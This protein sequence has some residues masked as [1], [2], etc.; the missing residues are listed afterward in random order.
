MFKNFIKNNPVHK[1][2]A[3]KFDFLFLFNL[4]SF[5]VKMMVFC[6]GMSLS[7]YHLAIHTNYFLLN[8]KYIDLIYFISLFIFISLSNFYEQI[9]DLPKLK[10]KDK[11]DN[12]KV[13]LN[14]LYVC[15]NFISIN[16]VTFLND[17]KLLV[18]A[19]LPILYISIESAIFLVL[20]YL[21]LKKMNETKIYLTLN[22]FV[23]KCVLIY[24]SLYLLFVSGS[25]YF[26]NYDIIFYLNNFLLLFL[27][28]MP[29]IFAYE[30][31]YSSFFYE[32]NYEVITNNS[33]LISL[34]CLIMLS[35]VFTVSFLNNNPFLSH[36][37]LISIPFFF[38]CFFR[39]E[40]KD[41]IRAY[42]YPILIA[43][44]L[45][46][47][48]LYPLLLIFQILIYYFSKYFYWHRFNF[49]YPKFVIEENE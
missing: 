33:R 25:L 16:K 23:L 32:N 29:I 21:I 11:N 39:G 19:I 12:Y 35:V 24:C 20:Y 46:S 13:N 8:F 48:T 9:G 18:L 43:N 4:P 37:S 5:F 30:I 3:K 15:P 10:W 41:Y 49:H 2:I 34:A 14:Y 22:Q 36:F 27:C 1:R 40:E 38:Y 17:F 26:D 47:W 42:T 45:I 7:Y 28:F 6:L 44:I 31:K